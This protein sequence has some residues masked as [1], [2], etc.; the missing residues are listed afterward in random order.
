M[1]AFSKSAN[2]LI[3]ETVAPPAVGVVYDHVVM[4]YG[5]PITIDYQVAG[6]AP[7]FDIVCSTKIPSK[8][9][10]TDPHDAAEYAAKFSAADWVAL[11]TGKT[12]SGR[13]K[14]DNLNPCLL[15]IKINTVGGPT[16]RIKAIVS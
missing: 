14:A 13:Y 15:A 8:T 3:D 12:A 16:T 2:S 6:T 10:M 1:S 4:W 7:N 9:G 11:D 5:G